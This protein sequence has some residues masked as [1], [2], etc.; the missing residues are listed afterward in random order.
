MFNLLEGGKRRLSLSLAPME[1]HVEREE[2]G[3]FGKQSLQLKVLEI[4]NRKLRRE[5]SHEFPET[6]LA[7]E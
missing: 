4:W 2:L 5:G 3:D 1:G 6:K 7:K